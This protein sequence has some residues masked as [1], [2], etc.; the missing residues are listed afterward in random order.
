MPVLEAEPQLFPDNLFC[1]TEGNVAHGECAE[2][3]HYGRGELNDKRW[4]VLQTKPRSEKQ[5]ARMLRAR[6][7]AHFL[8]QGASRRKT[9][10]RWVTSYRPLF[11]GYLFLYGE[12]EDFSASLMTN[13]VVN[14]L[15]VQ[16]PV[17]LH[18]ELYRIHELLT[19]GVNL[20][21]EPVLVEGDPVEIVSGSLAGLRGKVVR[22]DG[23]SRV[24]LGVKMINQGVSIL[25]EEW[26][27]RRV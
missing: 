9:Q 18:Q 10:R 16:D 24:I 6:G 2:H 12:A 11:P 5:L 26:M 19:L 3:G 27:L 20:S 22:L 8:P 15:P 7:V 21:A 23:Q 17:Q 25:V 13:K 1:E 14:A 4:M